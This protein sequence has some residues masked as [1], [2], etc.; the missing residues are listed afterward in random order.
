MPYA[1]LFHHSHAKFEHYQPRGSRQTTRHNRLLVIKYHW[2]PMCAVYNAA[3]LHLY[4]WIPTVKKTQTCSE[5][6]EIEIAIEIR[7]IS[8]RLED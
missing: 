4:Q 5:A 1:F 2:Y 3:D 6:M 8:Q 7:L